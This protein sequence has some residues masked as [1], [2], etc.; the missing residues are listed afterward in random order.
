MYLDFTVYPIQLHP[1]YVKGDLTDI[2]NYIVYCSLRYL[3]QNPGTIGFFDRP[4]VDQTIRDGSV[5]NAI[6]LEQLVERY[7]EFASINM[8]GS[9]VYRDRICQGAAYSPRR[10]ST[11]LSSL[12]GIMPALLPGFVP[13]PDPRGRFRLD[14]DRYYLYQ[15]H[16]A[17][18]CYLQGAF[19]DPKL[20]K[21]YVLYSMN[22]LDMDVKCL[23]VSHQQLTRDW[24]N[25]YFNSRDRVDALSE[26]LPEL[27]AMGIT[28]T[29][30]YRELVE[31]SLL[32]QELKDAKQDVLNL[33]SMPVR[34]T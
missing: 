13:F 24:T 15:L 31:Y 25:R 33:F 1:L 30:A 34:Y 23:G 14:K 12:V 18:A 6:P 29:L 7:P 22:G 9:A 16:P 32:Y 4:V 8:K 20:I 2:R 28:T 19:I 26:I 5:G 17:Y 3:L 27:S 11:T 21:S 10:N